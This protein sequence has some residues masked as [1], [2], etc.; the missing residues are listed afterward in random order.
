MHTIYTEEINKI[1]LRSNFYKRLQTFDR[2]TSYPYC[3]TVRKACKIEPLNKYNWL[4][5]IIILMKPKKSIIQSG[6][7]FQ[8]ICTEY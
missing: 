4:T 8:V 3:A 2:I 5:L 1:S 6:H 7:I